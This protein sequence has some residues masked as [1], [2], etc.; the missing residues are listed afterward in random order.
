MNLRYCLPLLSATLVWAQPRFEVR[1]PAGQSAPTLDG[2]LLLLLSNDEKAEPRFQ[3]SDGPE[4]QMVFG[5]DVEAWQPGT[6]RV[7]KLCQVLDQ[8]P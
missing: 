6:V 7:V 1:L 8:Q 4:S 5:V 2:R 3:I